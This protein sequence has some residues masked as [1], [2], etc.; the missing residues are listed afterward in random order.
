MA[1]TLGLGAAT[2]PRAAAGSQPTTAPCRATRGRSARP[3]RLAR[4]ALSTAARRHR[5]SRERGNAERAP[6]D[7]PAFCA[8]RPALQSWVDW[9]PRTPSR[10][11]AHAGCGA[12]S[13]LGM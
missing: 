10:A 3:T 1:S 11:A 9:Q 4:L 12:R 8:R 5:I 2:A 6:S 7:A 13:P